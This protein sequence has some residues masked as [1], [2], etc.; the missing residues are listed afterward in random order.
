MFKTTNDFF[1]LVRT[2]NVTDIDIQEFVYKKTKKHNIEKLKTLLKDIEFYLFVEKEFL[3][4]E[5]TP[6]MWTEKHNYYKEKG[7]EMPFKEFENIMIKLNA[8]K[9]IDTSNE[10][11][12]YRY[13]DEE[14]IFFPHEFF[15]IY[16]LGNYI[17][18]LIDNV[19]ESNFKHE[20]IFSNNGFILFEH[21]LKEYVKPKGTKGRLSDI[22]FFYRSM[23][24][25]KPQFIHQ[26][27]ERFKEWFFENY[28]YE[29]LGKIKTYSQVKNPN[30]LKH[31]SIAL[32]WFKNQS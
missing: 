17:G 2:G 28:D 16:Q 29:D 13:Y 22:H 6:E 31:Y 15:C 20:N 14:K 5:I 10:P 11:K 9:G 30:R 27:P 25:S 32:E 1:D 19:K 3:I 18:K 4:S 21:T 26:R 12:Y 23:F 7:K 24:D 8:K